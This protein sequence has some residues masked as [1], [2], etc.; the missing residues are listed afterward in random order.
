MTDTDDVE[1][2]FVRRLFR[3]DDPTPTEAT[4]PPLTES[5]AMRQWV[6]ELFKDNE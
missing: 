1:R 2:G 4:D 5:E 6:R 3:R